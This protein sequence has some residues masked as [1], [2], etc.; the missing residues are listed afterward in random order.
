[1]LTDSASLR[2]SLTAPTS[3]LWV[4][5]SA[6]SA[7]G[8]PSAIDEITASTA[9]AARSPFG[10]DSP[11]SISRD[12]ASASSGV[13]WSPPGAPEADVSIGCA[14]GSRHAQPMKAAAWAASIASEMPNNGT[15]PRAISPAVYSSGRFSGSEETIAPC[16]LLVFSA[17]SKARSVAHQSVSEQ[18][19][20]RGKSSTSMLRSKPPDTMAVKVAVIAGSL[21]QMK[22]W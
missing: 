8:K 5:P 15:M 6:F 21:F 14:C 13:T 22:V 17:D 1:M 2:L 7:T 16:A 12:F 10:T 9:L 19:S 4:T 3:D 18:R 20:G 11:A